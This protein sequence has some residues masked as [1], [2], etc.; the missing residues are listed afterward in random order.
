M[1]T[2]Y[3]HTSPNTMPASE[4]VVFGNAPIFGDSIK[5]RGDCRDVTGGF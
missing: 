4:Q 3:T 1:N 5:N 2:I